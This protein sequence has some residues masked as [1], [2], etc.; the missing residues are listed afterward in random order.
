MSEPYTWEQTLQDLTVTVN[1]G[2][3]IRGKDIICNITKDHLTFGIKG[4]DLII[5]ADFHKPVRSHESVWM[6][7]GPEVYITLIKVNQMEWWSTPF[8]GHT[9]IDVSKI[10]PE[11]SKL[12]DLDSET[13]AMVEKMMAEQQAKASGKPTPQEVEQQE[14]LRKLQSQHPEFDFS[15]AKIQ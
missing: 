13:R 3:G 14:M 15:Q 6:K 8:V 4:R 10:E 11:N 7:D 2:E 12:S 1:V 9:E 5:D